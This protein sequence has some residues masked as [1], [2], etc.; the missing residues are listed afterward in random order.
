VKGPITGGT[1]NVPFSPLPSKLAAQYGYQE[2]EFFI[3]GTATAYASSKELT[4]DGKWDVKP[5]TTAPYTTRILVRRPT[6][7]AKFNGTVVVEWFNVSSGMDADPDFG[8]AH[9]EL[10]RQGYAWVGVSAQKTGVMGGGVKIPIPVP[11][12]E[13][14]ALKEW[15]ATRYADLNHPGDDYSYDMFSQAGQTILQAGA[16][17]PLGGLV[18]THVIA[19]GESQSAIRMATYVNAIHPV[20]GVFDAFLIHSRSSASARLNEDPAQV[21]PK[22]VTIRT[23]LTAPVLQ[24]VTETDLFGTLN[25]FP[26]RQPDTDKLR[27]WELAGTAHADQFTLDYGTESGHEWAPDVSVDFT[28]LCGTINRGPHTWV[29][30]RAFRALNDWITGKGAPP[31]GEPLAVS[32]GT[33]ITRDADGNATGGIRTPQVDVP[34]EVLSGEPDPSKSF[35]CQLF[36]STKPFDEAELAKR[37]PTHEDYVA[38][39]KEAAQRTVDIGFLLPEDQQLIVQ[40]AEAAKI[41][42]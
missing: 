36:G 17:N 37:Y 24:L 8:F 16:S 31:K 1:Y 29:V 11:G 18:P 27:T 26:S 33:K 23:D 6:D 35:I 20:A 41:P 19:A 3:S 2:Q 15:D 5:S 40:A 13:L 22:V 12:L 38:K 34:T 39:V 14:K 32:D 10:M 25:F 7:A 42:R 9:D 21:V 30:R 4:A 28:S